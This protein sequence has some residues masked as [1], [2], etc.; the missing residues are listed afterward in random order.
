MKRLLLL[1]PLL[2]VASCARFPDSGS[3]S[4]N[5]AR[6]SFTVQLQGQV[7]DV[8]DD[9]PLTNYL[10]FVAIRTITT[11]DVPNVGAPVPITGDSS[12]AVGNGFVAGSPTHF[13]T[14]DTSRP[15][16]PYP[17]HL[18]RFDPSSTPD[19]PSNA[20]NLL[21]FVDTASIRGPIVNFVRPSAS[22]NK[23]ELKFD[24]F[25]N[26]LAN[27]D[28]EAANIKKI[29]INVLTM[30]QLATSGI[31]TRA[32]DG[33][34]NSRSPSEINTSITIDLRTNNL[35]TNNQGLEPT[36]DVVN[37]DDPSLDIQNYT[38]EIRRP[39]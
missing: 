24:L 36:G 20:T 35:V 30:N 21:S 26:Q 10:Y 23:N 33:L 38:V 31:S 17:Y 1:T 25:L 13:V 9:T 11:E 12:Q 34:G 28:E 14:F 4:S 19:D 29:Q 22:S 27:T 8:Q 7:N 3:A 18:F 6:L 5:F 16:Q 2:L 32:W 15:T 39:S 37:G